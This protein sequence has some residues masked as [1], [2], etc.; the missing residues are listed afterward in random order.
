VATGSGLT[1]A[2]AVWGGV[3]GFV[4]PAAVY[5]LAHMD[6]GITSDELLGAGLTAIVTAAGVAGTVF[7]VEN[8]PKAQVGQSGADLL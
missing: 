4:A 3:I 7:G 5:L 1:A 2:K 6:G 8:K